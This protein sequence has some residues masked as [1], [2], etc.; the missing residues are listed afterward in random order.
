VTAHGDRGTGNGA[1]GTLN[2]EPIV[3]SV[4][5]LGNVLMGDDG[6]GPYVVERLRAAYAC[7]EGV[8]LCDAGTPG[9]DLIPFLAD[10]EACVIVDAVKSAGEPGE[11][12]VYRLEEILAHAPLP[13]LGPHEP[14]VK[15]TLI[16]L[17]LAGRGPR[18]VVLVG[19]IPEA[20]EA[21][22]GL[23]ATIRGRVPDVMAQV[24]VELE[25]LG[26]PLVARE[27]PGVPETWWERPVASN[28]RRSGSATA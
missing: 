12:R 19:V 18:E 7:P 25:R 20:L 17:H 15:E 14:G 23:S 9:L 27:V 13:R 6:V 11:M 3:I 4:I 1:R 26:A 16:T 8:E 5:G 10:T 2:G 21:H 24:C 28:C 22:P